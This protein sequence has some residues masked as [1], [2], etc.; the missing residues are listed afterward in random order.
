MRERVVA[1]PG[2]RLPAGG[3]VEQPRMV[4]E[5]LQPFRDHGHRRL[6]VAGRP[7]RLGRERVLP[8]RDLVRLAAPAADGEH[9]RPVLRG[10][11]A[12]PRRRVGEEDDR[13]GGR[14]DRL[15]RQRE[16]RAPAEH[17]VQLLV[18]PRGG[19]ELVV[20]LDDVLARPLRRGKR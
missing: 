7:V 14:V 17:D 19:A 11:R 12:A 5:L 18:V 9:G 16:R 8:R 13:A 20:L 15:A 4:G 2:E 6:P 1:A 10:D 3:P